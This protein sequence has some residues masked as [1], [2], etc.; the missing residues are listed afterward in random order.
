MST[1]SKHV[2]SAE[3]KTKAAI[4]S[5]VGGFKALDSKVNKARSAVAAL[6]GAGGFALLVKS[7]ANYLDTLGKTSDKLGLTTQALQELSFVVGQTSTV[8]GPQFETALQRMVRRIGDARDGTS[9]AVNALDTLNLSV[10]KL[11]QLNADQAFTVIAQAISEMDNEMEQLAITQQIF[12]SEGVALINTLRRGADGISE[13]R[14][15]AKGLGATFSRESAAKAE[16]FNDS[17]DKLKVASG[18]LA[19]QIITNLLPS[20]T[21]TV[22][23]LTNS[24]IPKV[25]RAIE[26]LFGFRRAVQELTDEDIMFRIAEINTRLTV[27]LDGKDQKRSGNAEKIRNFRKELIELDNEIKAREKA[28]KSELSIDIVRGSDSNNLAAL[29]EEDEK[30]LQQFAV[31]NKD[32][33]KQI[34]DELNEEAEKS[35]ERFR[36]AW[37]PT[38]DDFSRGVGD[39]FGEAIFEQKSFGDAFQEAMRGVARNVIESLAAIAAKKLVLFALEKAGII[40]TAAASALAGNTVAAAWAPAAALVSLATLGANAIPASAALAST[41]ALSAGLS[42]GSG[43][44]GVAHDGLDYVPKTGTYLLEKGERVVKKENNNAMMSNRP[45][46]INFNV[47]SLDPRG[48]AQVLN[49]NRNAIVGIIQSAYTDN[50][51]SGGPFR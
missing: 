39:A 25:R 11:S 51:R 29:L 28:R 31:S 34:F 6:A 3:D 8:S 27:L 22:N 42:A 48:A 23:K 19:N 37:Q 32:L 41:T 30:L 16:E 49:Q 43:L 33:T 7:T 1:R 18:S 5:A 15:E 36:Q 45:V 35:A 4:K 9:A 40:S 46:N 10:S 21:D 50:G 17:L 44:L 38:L 20:L 24:L 12:D 47:N 13:L 26:V 2:I 14:D